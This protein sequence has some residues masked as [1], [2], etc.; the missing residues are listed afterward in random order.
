[1]KLS[2]LQS[3]GIK[4]QGFLPKAK[5]E[6]I[7][8]FSLFS[9]VLGV[10]FTL[11][12]SGLSAQVSFTG[13]YNQNFD[14][15]GT[16]STIPSGWSHIGALGGSNSTW[17]TSI[18][19]SGSPSAASTTTVNNT[20]IVA[21]NSFSGT[22][23]SQAFNYSGSTT[24]DRSLG[25]S[26][27]TG[28]GNILQLR[29]TNN[30]G[31]SFNTVQ[32]SYNIRRFATSSSAESL[33]GYF[34]FASINGGTTW[35]ALTALNPT[36]ANVPNTNGTSNFNQ[37]ITLGSA[38]AVGSELR[39]RFVDDNSTSA[40]P[41][42]RI[43]LD[44]VAISVV[45]PGVCGVPSALSTTGITT[46]SATLNW[47]SVV[48]ASSYNLQWRPTG[49]T[50]FT[51]VNGLTS[52]SFN[53]SG[54]TQGTSYEF[55]VQAVCSGTQSAFSTLFSFS[56]SIPGTCGT[57]V[58][59]NSTGITSSSANLSWTALSG[60][61][62]Y[63][64]Q[65]KLASA[66]TFTTV[67]NLT[68]TSFVLSGLA[69]STA[70]N[71]QVQ[72]ICSGTAGT[73][74]ALANFSTTVNTTV[75][76]VIYIWSGAIQ[77]TSATV[78]AKVTT[79]STTCRAVVSTA[80]DLSNPVYS[81]FASA[82]SSN[83]FMAKMNVTGLQPNTQY[84]Y[85]VESG[86]VLDNS[87][88]D[89]GK[90]K[91]PAS[92]A[93]SFSFAHGS[94]TGNGNHAVFTAIQ[95]KNPLFFLET[96]DFHYQDPNSTNIS[97]HRA[98]Y[99]NNVLGQAAAG[100]L[101]KNTAVA[102]MW[103]DHDYCGNNNSGS[104]Q[105]GTANARQAYQEYVPHY[106]L[107]AGSG[108]VPIYQAFTIGRVRFILADLRSL[109]ASGTMFGTT[110]KAWFK[111]QCLD[112]KNNCQ[113][114][115]WVTGTSWGGTQSDNWGGFSAER[116][117]LSNFFR[118][119]S[120][121]NMFIMSG[122]AH[123]MAIDNGS[124][125]DFSTGSNNPNDYPVFSA[126]GLNQSGSNKG[127]TYSQG[128]FTNPSSTTGQYGV[129]NITDNGGSSISISFQG[130]RTSGNTTT[131]SVITTYNFSRTVCAP[132]ARMA[133]PVGSISTRSLEDGA[134]V[135][136]SWDLGLKDKN[137]EL[138]KS[139]AEG[140]S[141]ATVSDITGKGNMVDANP[142]SGWNAYR[143]VDA[144]GEVLGS[145]KI[146][147]QGK[148]KINLSPNPAKTTMNVSFDGFEGNMDGRV[149]VYNSMRMWELEQEV[150]AASGKAGFTLDVSALTTGLY[151]MI[152]EK[153]GM[154]ISKQFLVNK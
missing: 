85:G 79:A 107:V 73:Y 95:N 65:W 113:V 18:P 150:K 5:S 7:S 16:G 91:T 55:Q 6:N 94:C 121:Q 135:S 105:A 35:T 138:Q 31:T 48:G 53:L 89:I 133:V 71:F 102:Y 33:P 30:S 54:L 12:G 131:E 109:R 24:S 103:D 26:P 59:L 96:G 25:T 58:G 70:Y 119:N 132:F 61:S 153:N 112:A 123:L 149:L 34:V 69:P 148:A 154:T 20:L 151:T 116:T 8:D 27:T 118:D 9:L 60:A 82:S 128:T 42:Q 84:F 78:V 117:E 99:E 144:N 81:A 106:P 145:Q 80:A 46:N 136:V 37:Q 139:T 32:I 77:P 92:G 97:T 140:G 125:H 111:Q 39:L 43:G 104:G 152:Y 19:A 44:N 86:G 115:A 22:S 114:I 126:A 90:F 129:V 66:S 146:F 68:T 10:L 134:Q 124:N 108:N 110:Q 137:F 122:D 3:A 14:G 62:T 83:N 23:N 45:A 100:N 143:I 67:S 147:V 41:D 74:S 29:L 130:Y 127:G 63:N 98:P 56:T 142:V 50:T 72:A 47:Q 21:S 101:L 17:G 120:I 88:T 1:M 64:L 40:S 4:S 49:A 15:L 51:S 36:S 11:V 93:F 87:S 2:V 52:T 57:V 141:F 76:E 13:T 75:N 28:A 38:V